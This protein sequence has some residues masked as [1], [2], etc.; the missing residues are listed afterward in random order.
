MLT[1]Y[2]SPQILEYR[3]ALEKLTGHRV[4]ESYLYLLSLSKAIQ[5]K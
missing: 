1:D 2:Y 3:E 5:I 4:K